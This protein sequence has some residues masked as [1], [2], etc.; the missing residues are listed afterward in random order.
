MAAR[1]RSSTSPRQESGQ[2]SWIVTPVSY[3]LAVPAYC[4]S[5]EVTH[6][7]IVVATATTMQQGE[8]APA[9]CARALPHPSRDHHVHSS[10]SGKRSQ[11][12]RRQ[13]LRVDKGILPYCVFQN[14]GT[15][16]NTL[17]LT[18]RKYRSKC[19]PNDITG[20]KWLEI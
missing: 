2:F 1:S 20:V 5:I 7:N 3:R 10:P 19:P 16:P 18:H 17:T 14:H 6:P 9:P 11:L 15:N 8:P 13:G 4:R 12:P